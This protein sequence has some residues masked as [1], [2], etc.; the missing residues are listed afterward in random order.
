MESRRMR[1][2]LHSVRTLNAKLSRPF[3]RSTRGREVRCHPVGRGH[4]VSVLVLVRRSVLAA[5][6]RV[7]VFAVAAVRTLVGQLEHTEQ[8]KQSDI[9]SNDARQCRGI[10][11]KL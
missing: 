6:L 7:A 8:S 3:I 2:H 11:T 5:V 4:S 9:A 10:W 1:F